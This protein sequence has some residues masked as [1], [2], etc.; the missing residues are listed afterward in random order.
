MKSARKGDCGLSVTRLPPD[1]LALCIGGR[2]NKLFL[3][4][5]QG[6]PVTG[7][8]RLH[9]VTAAGVI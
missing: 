1:T 2:E 4:W 7:Q 5:L 8:R 9:A 6:C 3:P